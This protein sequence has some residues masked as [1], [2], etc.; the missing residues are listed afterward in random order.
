MQTIPLIPNANYSF[1]VDLEETKN[2]TIEIRLRW[3]SI[4]QAWYID[5]TG[6]TFDFQLDGQKLVGGVN[7]LKPHA[8]L[9]LGGLFLIDSE[10][11][12]EDSDFDLLGDRY[13]LIYVTKA[14]MVDISI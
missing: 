9:E 8:V 3:N 1:L 5:L 11:K 13:K 10:D 4:E 7:F 14:E 12:A 6:Q 2:Q